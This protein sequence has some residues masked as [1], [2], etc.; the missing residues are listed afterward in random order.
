MSDTGTGGNSTGGEVLTAALA[1]EKRLAAM[2]SNAASTAS[3]TTPMDVDAPDPS[4]ALKKSLVE[5]MGFDEHTAAAGVMNG[6]GTL[7]GAIDWITRQQDAEG[8]G[9][10][11]GSGAMEMDADGNATITGDS[12]GGGVAQ[13]Y[14]CNDCG[15]IM[16]NMAN[17]ELHANKTGHSDFSESTEAIKPLTAEEKAAKVLEIKGLLAAKRAARQEDEKKHAIVAEKQRREM[18]QQMVKTKEEL[19]RAEMKRSADA[20]K[21]E[22]ASAKTERERIRAEIA[23]D[24]LER[25]ANGGKM[26]S[27]LGVDGYNPSAIQYEVDKDV[28]G[29]PGAGAGGAAKPPAAAAPA[30][31]AIVKTSAIPK[32]LKVA[33]NRPKEA[34]AAECIER[35]SQYRAGGDG[36]NCLKL[37]GV[38]IGNVVDNKTEMKYRG[39]SL[40]SKA[41]K[42]KVKGLNGGRKLLEV[43]GWAKDAEEEKLVLSDE[44]VDWNFLTQVRQDVA[45]ALAKYAQ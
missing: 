6:G 19:A 39:I 10:G 21:R 38:F 12:G 33:D 35:V 1:R 23:A 8:E 13:S 43:C 27:Q 7:E 24:K 26:K 5:E 28:P 44:D 36:G 3:T 34:Q 42:A 29:A 18:G 22:K 20:K 9:E 41:Y 11:E 37:L 25:Q 17:L 31:A 2:S 45:A 4:E 16:S 32:K 15:K 14:R 30:P 40:E